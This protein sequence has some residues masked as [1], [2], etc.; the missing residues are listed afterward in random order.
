MT[1]LSDKILVLL[2]LKLMKPDTI[3]PYPSVI[4]I[5]CFVDGV[6][7]TDAER[8]V[9]MLHLA[10]CDSC[11]REWLGLSKKTPRQPL[12]FLPFPMVVLVNLRFANI[13]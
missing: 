11:R 10:Y 3:T 5:A 13:F 1:P 7:D 9:I 8:D 2:A 4:D 6:L 12:P